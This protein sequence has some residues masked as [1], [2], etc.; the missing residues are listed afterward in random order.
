MLSKLFPRKL[1]HSADSKLRGK[2][3]MSDAVNI[4]VEGDDRGEDGGNENVIKPV[5]SN[6]ALFGDIFSSNQKTVLGKVTDDK[7]NV[8]YFFVWDFDAAYCG[9]YAY[10][11]DLYFSGH[12]A[13]TIIRIYRSTRFN[14][15]VDSFVNAEITYSQKKYKAVS[16]YDY[17]DTPFLFFTDN[18]NEPRKLN[19][20]RAYY[21]STLS[22]ASSYGADNIDDFITAC[23]KAPVHPVTFSWSSDQ[24]L[25]VSE[26]RGVNGFQFAYQSVFK[27]GNVSAISTYSEIAVPPSYINQGA[28]SSANLLAHNVCELTIPSIDLTL[29]VEKVKVLARRGNTGS[30]FEITELENF[31]FN[32]SLTYSFNNTSVN[33][34]VSKDDQIKQFDNL[35]KIAET[36]AIEGNRVFYGNYVEGFDNVPTEATV[37]PISKVR[38]QDFISYDVKLKPATCHSESVF[39]QYYEDFFVLGSE[40][41]QVKNKN[42]AFVIDT[43]ELPDNTAIEEND[44]FTLTFSILPDNNWHI[45]DAKDAYHQHNQLGDFWENDPNFGVEG[46]PEFLQNYYWQNSVDSGQNNVANGPDPLDGGGGNFIPAQVESGVVNSSTNNTQSG[47]TENNFTWNYIFPDGQSSAPTPTRFGTSAA[48]PL[49]VQAKPVSISLTLRADQPNITRED[50]STAIAEALSEESQSGDYVHNAKFQVVSANFG[51]TYSYSLGL[52]NGSSFS[53]TD[54][55]AKLIVMTGDNEFESGTLHGNFILNKATVELGF[56]EDKAYT[57]DTGNDQTTDNYYFGEGIYE[58]PDTGE[59][60]TDN[61]RVGIYIKQIYNVEVLTCLRK[62]K[63]NSPWHVYD[64]NHIYGVTPSEDLS[65]GP[66]AEDFWPSLTDPFGSG[67]EFETHVGK[68]NFT[69]NLTENKPFFKG[70]IAEAATSLSCFTVLDG[71]GGIAGGPASLSGDLPYDSENVLVVPPLEHI[72]G[73]SNLGSAPMQVSGSSQASLLS[74]PIIDNNAR[75]FMPL[76]NSNGIATPLI[77]TDGNP[78]TVDISLQH[79]AALILGD[80][81]FITSSQGDGERSFKSGA[82]HAFGVVYYDYRG[83]ASSV[84]PIGTAYAPAYYNRPDNN[85]G[86]IEMQIALL[87]GAPPWAKDFQIVYSGNTS[88]SDFTQYTTGGAFYVEGEDEAEDG[89]IYVSLN[90]LQENNDVSYT[91]AF[92][93]RSPEGAADMYTFKEGDLLRVISYYTSDDNRVFVDNRFLF[94]VAGQRTLSSGEDNP[95]F[96]EAEDADI[97]HPSK[98]GNFIILKNKPDADG[99]AYYDVQQGGN[100]PDSP[101]HNWNK[102]CVVEIISPSDSQAEDNI[103]FYE[104]SKVFQIGQHNSTITM[105]NGDVWWRRVPVNMPE[106]DG[107]FKNLILEEGSQPRFA[108][109]Y[110]ETKAFNDTVR[111]ADV[112]GEGKLKIVLP[113]AQE[114]RRSTSI[115]YSEKNNPASSVFQLTSFNPAKLQFKDLP[116]EHGN[117]NY[118]L[119][120]QDSLFVIQANRC[121]S[122]PV[123]RNIITTASNDQSLVAASKVLGTQ[124]YYAGKYG[125][126]NNPES[127]CAVGNSVYF[128]SKSNSQVYR[129]NP[130]N[131]IEVISDKGM[132]SFF[133]KTFRDV[134]S[135]QSELG[136]AKIVGGYDPAKDE[137]IIS[138]YNQDLANFESGGGGLNTGTPTSNAL[139]EQL[140]QFI[141]AVISVNIEGGSL[142]NLNSVPTPIRNFYVNYQSN[143]NLDESHLLSSSGG[144]LDSSTGQFV[145]NPL[146]VDNVTNSSVIV[147]ALSIAAQNAATRIQNSTL[148]PI[149]NAIAASDPEE[150]ADMSNFQTSESIADY[151]FSRNI[152]IESQK[153]EISLLQLELYGGEGFSRN[154][155]SSGSAYG[156][157]ITLT[158]QLADSQASAA[159]FE[160]QVTE[161]SETIA[162]DTAAAAAAAAVAAGEISSLESQIA[163]IQNQLDPFL[164]LNMSAEQIQGKLLKL[165]QFEAAM[166][167]AEFSPTPESLTTI[168]TSYAAYSNIGSVTSFENAM[169]TLQA[170]ENVGVDMSE[171]YNMANVISTEQIQQIISDGIADSSLE[172]ALSTELYEVLNNAGY[173]QNVAGLNALVADLDQWQN[174]GTAAD[175]GTNLSYGEVLGILTKYN[176]FNQLGYNAAQLG[177]IIDAYNDYTNTGLSPNEVQGF[178]DLNLSPAEIENIVAE[179]ESYQEQG[180]VEDFAAFNSLEDQYGSLSAALANLQGY[181]DINPDWQT[182][183]Q[184]QEA[185]QAAYAGWNQW[186]SVSQAGFSSSD[187]VAILGDYTAFSTSLGFDV[188]NGIFASDVV[189]GLQGQLNAAQTAASE[190]I[191]AQ[192]SA[193]ANLADAL[194]AQTDAEGIAAAATSAQEAA[195]AAQA[196]AVAAAEA[197]AD[198]QAA[199]ELQLENANLAA[200]DN[201]AAL[202]SFA[203]SLTQTETDYQNI[204]SGIDQLSGVVGGWGN[205]ILG[206]GQQGFDTNLDQEVG[207][208]DLLDFLVAYGSTVE[209]LQGSD[210]DA[211]LLDTNDDGEIGS[212]D[213]LDFLIAYGATNEELG[214]TGG[215]SYEQAIENAFNSGVSQGALNEAGLSTEILSLQKDLIDVSLSLGAHGWSPINNLAEVDYNLVSGGQTT[216]F[217]TLTQ[218]QRNSLAPAV[219]AAL[220]ELKTWTSAFRGSFNFY[221][222][223]GGG[224]NFF[225][226]T[227]G[228]PTAGSS[229]VVAGTPV[230]WSDIISQNMTDASGNALQGA[231]DVVYGNTPNY[232][233][234]LP[235]SLNTAITN[236]GYD[237]GYTAGFGDGQASGGNGGNTHTSLKSYIDSNGI[238]RDEYQRLVVAMQN[239]SEDGGAFTQSGFDTNND[240]EIGSADLLGFLI[241]YGLTLDEFGTNSS[242]WLNPQYIYTPLM[243]N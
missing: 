100:D 213:L 4:S 229:G 199:A 119:A 174:I 84:Y 190:A 162:S 89:N 99:F 209:E 25:P 177:D 206:G 74:G 12:D 152:T 45:Y 75:G 105:A 128:A 232:Q 233:M 61:R 68:L 36:Q 150:A 207:S 222:E 187:V 5:K 29:E 225:Q 130:S 127:V 205:L 70:T 54:S 176:D 31:D 62:G 179:L 230:S 8:I 91:E 94:E 220:N 172:T 201:L 142:F 34:A 103:V 109:Y 86:R 161:L 137:Y 171:V 154:D 123:D 156:N 193:E 83:R 208:A 116:I 144:Y 180:P 65:E 90:Y 197:A 147:S 121:A 237:N 143:H 168:L 157:I 192:A 114:S 217:E 23:P 215:V 203:S 38:P 101:A 159:A 182:H 153:N 210:Y 14:F 71:K 72:F 173:S 141:D 87:H 185:L 194:A 238:T 28:N 1:N 52:N 48:N 95:L 133:R 129:F 106:F 63:P 169:N 170:L 175:L 148:A 7:Y 9:V 49:I 77:D 40:V 226:Y 26:F 19:V 42:S 132:K 135:S 110:L 198:L 126:D 188:Q 134:V 228:S 79:S 73:I 236:A 149:I 85:Y 18:R 46:S 81:F 163:S 195:E 189:Q 107:T 234:W 55:F 3:D 66:F 214:F 115:M 117:I 140:Y 88:V 216:G 113:D 57:Y 184:A 111:N 122:V 124:R 44:Q 243:E 82:N 191:A 67:G 118:L 202:N 239:L 231:L 164:A 242:T 120:Q 131:G 186:E 76:H 15:E 196:T 200:Q 2:D 167:A 218:P 59:T 223:E 41:N 227:L 204:I 27:D 112:T 80:S 22:E 64:S 17:E 24:D 151:I 241:A 136:V 13:D 108:P 50:V 155:P 97:V 96:N 235:S 139:E 11:P 102:R 21:E 53:M 183:G 219:N 51:T 78:I 158:S 224:N 32:A 60:N 56:F 47:T 165:Q 221:D 125:C 212:A 98:Q 10:D 16:G 35:P 240:S 211:T 178:V 37:T 160:T 20:L 58:D 92:G 146:T 166:T 30:W 69:D 138:I 33:I 93:A 145:G 43:S 6:T 181:L 104:T 39:S